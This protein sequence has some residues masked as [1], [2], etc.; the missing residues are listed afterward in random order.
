MTPLKQFEKWYRKAVKAKEPIAD[1]LALSTASAKGKPSV[2]FV[3][4][5]KVTRDSVFFFTNYRSAKSKDLE[6]NPRAELA[7]F[8]P[9]IY[10]QIRLAGKVKRASAKDSDIYWASRPRESQLSALASP[11]SRVISNR[12]SLERKVKELERIYNGKPIPR[13]ST[14]GGFELRVNE[15]E[16]WTGQK[17]RLHKRERFRLR[18]GKWK[19]E[20]LAP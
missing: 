3:L 12:Q 14:W 13:P 5:K 19:R 4:F 2:R 16:F 8:W 18:Q 1:A 20:L 11:Q 10:L 7:I 15:A 6:E 9:R 17:F